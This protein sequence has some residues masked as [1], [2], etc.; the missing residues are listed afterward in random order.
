MGEGGNVFDQPLNIDL[1]RYDILKIAT[2]QG[3]DHATGCLPDYPYF[4]QYYKIIA[5][6]VSKQQALDAYPK[7]I[8]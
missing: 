3:D 5:I 7:A 4:K 1:R 2:G 8:Q 6:D